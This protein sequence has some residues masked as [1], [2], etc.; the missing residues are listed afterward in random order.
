M[1]KFSICKFKMN[2]NK[3][4]QKQLINA[5]LFPLVSIHIAW[6]NLFKI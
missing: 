6:E 5:E 1:Y 2:Q 4:T 3:I